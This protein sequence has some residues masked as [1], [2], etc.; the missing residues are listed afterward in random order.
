MKLF[1]LPAF[2]DKHLDNSCTHKEAMTAA[3][4]TLIRTV[5]MQKTRI[6]NLSEQLENLRQ[7]LLFTDPNACW[8]CRELHPLQCSN[9]GSFPLKDAIKDET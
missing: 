1:D 8:H 7:P 3:A 6:D 9:C 4:H 2:I 5:S